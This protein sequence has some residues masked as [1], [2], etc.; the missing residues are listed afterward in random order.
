MSS[1]GY[2]YAL[3]ADRET[4]SYVVRVVEGGCPT[5][6]PKR[7]ELHERFLTAYAMTMFHAEKN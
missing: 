4:V 7:H 5:K 3:P 1:S 2:G 6:F